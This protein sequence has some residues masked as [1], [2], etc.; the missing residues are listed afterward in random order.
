MRR[1]FAVLML[2]AVCSGAEAS[3]QPESGEGLQGVRAALGGSAALDG[4]RTLRLEGTSARIVGPLR[5]DSRV[6][7]TIVR[8]DRYLRVDVLSLGVRSTE[9]SV[10]FVRGVAVQSAR[11]PDGARIDPEALIPAAARDQARRAAAQEQRRDLRRL[12]LGFLAGPF[13]GTSMTV[14]ARRI[15]EAPEGRA[16]MNRVVFEDGSDATLF[17][18]TRTHRPLMVAWEGPDVL[19]QLRSAT[20]RTDGGAAPAS[21]PSDVSHGVEHRFY[22]SDFRAVGTLRWPFL[23]RHAV[24]GEMVEEL[25]FDRIVINPPVDLAVFDGGTVTP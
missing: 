16:D 3:G 9:A 6:T 25:R 10:G 4:V 19:A 12:L 14:A 23:I 21:P 2:A 24:A 20:N 7:M 18:D 1:V 17:S 11:G 22:F 15:A 8:P 5:L 13:D